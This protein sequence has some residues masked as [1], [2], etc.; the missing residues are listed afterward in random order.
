MPEVLFF[1]PDYSAT[2]CE[3]CLAHAPSG[4]I[5][6]DAERHCAPKGWLSAA[7]RC[8]RLGGSVPCECLS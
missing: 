3:S 2:L 1:L 8:E 7:T 5:V 6:Y 4:A